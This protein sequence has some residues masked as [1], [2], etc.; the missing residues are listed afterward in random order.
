MELNPQI[1][2]F[3]LFCA[4]RRGREW[5]TL[6]DEMCRVAGRGLYQ[7]LRHKDLR[8]MGLSFSLNHIEETLRM[9]EAVTG[10]EFD[11]KSL[12]SQTREPA[13]SL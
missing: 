13:E 10:T 5:P 8:K 4:Q 6:Y 3:I 12:D 2:G 1:A 7:N 9:V 11:D